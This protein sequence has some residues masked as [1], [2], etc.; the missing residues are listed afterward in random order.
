MVSSTTAVRAVLGAA[1]VASASAGLCFNRYQC[2]YHYASNVTGS[3]EYSWDLSPLCQENPANMYNFKA[4]ANTGG[5]RYIFNICG[6]SSQACVPNWPVY[7]NRG[8]IVQLIDNSTVAGPCY[9]INNNPVPCTPQCA[10]LDNK[11]Y[12]FSP[13]SAADPTKGIQLT[14]DGMP[15]NAM[16]PFACPNTAPNGLPLGRQASMQITCDK[17]IPGFIVD[18]VTQPDTCS[19][20]IAG[21]SAQACAST[22]DRFDNV[23]VVE[24][25][26]G[27]KNFGFVVLGVFL[28][29]VVGFVIRFGNG[30]GWWDPVKNRVCRRGGSALNTGATASSAYKTITP[31]NAAMTTS[32]Y[33]TAA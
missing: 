15:Q 1:V 33:G 31:S 12:K 26:N 17:S 2:V 7:D 4:P 24:E 22:V 29:L 28:T 13:L 6:L 32:A 9:D 20:I 27:G 3:P 30:R 25:S 19:Y 18:S 5:A 14:F 8:V 16:S 21:R 10:V 11:F 23:V